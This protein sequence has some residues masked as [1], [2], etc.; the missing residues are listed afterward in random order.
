MI[1]TGHSLKKNNDRKISKKILASPK[2]IIWMS[3]IVL[4]FCIASGFI[5]K[6][7]IL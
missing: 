7:A 6:F 5:I 3:M 2:L 4:I 1:F